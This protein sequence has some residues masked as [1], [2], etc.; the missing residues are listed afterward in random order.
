MDNAVSCTHNATCTQCNRLRDSRIE[1]RLTPL[2][3]RPVRAACSTARV[4]ATSPRRDIVIS[5]CFSYSFLL[6]PRFISLNVG[7]EDWPFHRNFR[8][9]IREK[10]HC[11]F[12]SSLKLIED[13]DRVPVGRVSNS[14]HVAKWTCRLWYLRYLSLS[15]S[16][17]ILRWK[18]LFQFRFLVSIFQERTSKLW[19]AASDK[20]NLRFV[21]CFRNTKFKRCKPVF[22]WHSLLTVHTYVCDLFAQD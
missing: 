8:S 21:G 7:T 20:S 5:S 15:F 10:W 13:A 3:Y 1:D 14:M 17:L 9:W 11:Y 19:L 12:I 22:H 2:N 18:E 4:H 6:L 16:L